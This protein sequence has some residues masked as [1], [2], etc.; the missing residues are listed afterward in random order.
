MSVQLEHYLVLGAIL[1][2][3]GF[4]GALSRRNAVA[5]LMSI[6]IMFNAVNVTFVALSRYVTPTLLTGQV[7]AIFVIT[8]AAGEAALGLA[9]IIGIYRSRATVHVDEMDLLKG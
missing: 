2:A 8:V 7:F 3:I 9:I 4:Y 5:I 6:E 1:F